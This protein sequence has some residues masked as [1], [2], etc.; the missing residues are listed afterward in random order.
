[1]IPADEFTRLM[2]EEPQPSA[3]ETPEQY[4]HRYGLWYGTLG[5]RFQK[6]TQTVIPV[7][8]VHSKPNQEAA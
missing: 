3:G 4:A 5:Y 6:G 2:A 7:I 8:T 1:M